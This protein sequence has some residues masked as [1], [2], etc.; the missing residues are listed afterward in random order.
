L[1]SVITGKNAFREALAENTAKKW[2]KKG[3]PA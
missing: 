1:A 3:N 2:Q